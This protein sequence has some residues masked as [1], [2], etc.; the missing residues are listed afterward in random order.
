MMRLIYNDLRDGIYAHWLVMLVTW[1][2]P[3]VR[4]RVTSLII[5]YIYIYIMSTTL[6]LRAWGQLRASTLSYCP[7][8]GSRYIG[9]LLSISLAMILQWPYRRS[10][11]LLEMT[12]IIEIYKLPRFL[13]TTPFPQGKPLFQWHIFIS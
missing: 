10:R 8:S 4:S 2:C 7:I 5:V 13:Q 3:L 12:F 9:F 6:G 1:S 11:K